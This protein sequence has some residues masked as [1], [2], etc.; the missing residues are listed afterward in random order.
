MAGTMLYVL[1]RIAAEDPG[2]LHIP[3]AD[4][5]E[6]GAAFTLCGWC[7]VAYDEVCGVSGADVTC[8]SC[9]RI[10]AYCKSLHGV[11]RPGV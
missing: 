8:D 10:V 4:V 7:D 2:T 6:G 3:N 5:L 11:P 9:R 1:Y